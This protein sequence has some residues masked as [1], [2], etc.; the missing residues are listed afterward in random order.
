MRAG[1]LGF[2]TT[3]VMKAFGD[4]FRAL[5]GGVLIQQPSFGR[6][7]SVGP[8]RL[9]TVPFWKVPTAFGTW[10]ATNFNP[11]TAMGWQA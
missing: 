4:N 6:D 3:H 10:S 9:A 2:I 7:P 5:Y 8:S 11:D 1:R